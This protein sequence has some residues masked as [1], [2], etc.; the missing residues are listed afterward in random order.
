MVTATRAPPRQPVVTTGPGIATAA[1]SSS[2]GSRKSS[3]SEAANTPGAVRKGSANEVEREPVQPARYD[4]EAV[5]RKH[6]VSILEQV[7]VV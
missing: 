2:S 4:K 1:A 7:S 6:M 3:S 5:K